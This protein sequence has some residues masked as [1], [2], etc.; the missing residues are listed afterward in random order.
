MTGKHIELFLVDGEPGGITT[1]EIAGWTGHVL[2]G[3]RKDIGEILRRPE[4]GR[5]GA[6]LLLGDD[7]EAIGGVTCYIGRTENFIHRFRDHK[8]NK[9]YWDRVVLITAKAD[10]SWIA[11][12]NAS[13]WAAYKLFKGG[14]VRVADW[15]SYS[16]GHRDWFYSDGI[17]PKGAGATAY[18]ALIRDTLRK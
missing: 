8:A 11:G 6:Y 5:N 15:Q 18:A 3:P 16:A 10:R 2:T 9:D 17:H 4:A 7:D 14:N 13:I 1:A 12:S